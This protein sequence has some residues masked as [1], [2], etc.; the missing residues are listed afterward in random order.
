[1]VAY[2]PACK[3]VTTHGVRG[4]M[5]ALPLCDGADFLSRFPA[6]YGTPQ[7]EKPYKVQSV[8]AQGTMLLVRL[9]EIT[10]RDAARLM[11]GHTLYFARAD[12]KLPQG[13][14][15]VEDIVGCTVRDADTGAVYGAV[16]AVDQSGAQDLYTVRADGGREYLLPA[17]REFVRSVDVENRLLLVTP[18][19]GLFSEPQS[20]REEP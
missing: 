7:G 20:E 17:V 5:R 16:T 13:S 18:I 6:L 4:E 12:A 9:A 1:M 15:F 14:Y 11:V 2:L 8:R 3:I 19:P 10:D